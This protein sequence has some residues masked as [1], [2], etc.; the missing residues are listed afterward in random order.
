MMAAHLLDIANSDKHTLKP[1][2]NTVLEFSAPVED[3]TT[4][5]FP[6]LGARL[7]YLDRH[8]ALALVYTIRKHYINVF[9][10]PK[11][12][13]DRQDRGSIGTRG[14]HVRYW[15]SHG[16]AFAAVSDVAEEDLSRFIEVFIAAGDG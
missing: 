8:K 14:Y 2:M 5:G 16:L 6:L 1:W 3:L 10:W 11:E 12:G 7:E 13:A 4:L 15:S 9:I